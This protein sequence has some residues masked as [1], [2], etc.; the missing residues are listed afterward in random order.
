VLLTHS[1]PLDSSSRVAL[2]LALQKFEPKGKI[3]DVESCQQFLRDFHRYKD[4]GGSKHLSTLLQVPIDPKISFISNFSSLLYGFNSDYLLIDDYVEEELLKLFPATSS[5]FN[6]ASRLTQLKMPETSKTDPT[7]LITF[8]H[9]FLATFSYY[10]D[11]FK[12]NFSSP[13]HWNKAICKLFCSLLRP[14][15]LP[16]RFNL[17]EITEFNT[18]QLQFRKIVMQLQ[19]SQ[20]LLGKS[21]SGG[22]IASGGGVLSCRN[23]KLPHTVSD[24]KKP[25]TYST[26]ATSP[27]H[28]AKD[29][30]NWKSTKS[31]GSSSLSHSPPNKAPAP[32][33]P[34]KVNVA[35]TLPVVPPSTSS[36]DPEVIFDSGSAVTTIP[37]SNFRIDTTP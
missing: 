15:D 2:D 27:P 26:C 8:L 24:C 16:T 33:G 35:T 36:V 12:K 6:A 10:G 18:L 17:Q 1:P 7:A 22:G 3:I 21:A 5:A 32:R 25:C 14:S 34:P 30:P 28:Q 9:N 20:Q 23:C 31:K 13:L 37:T 19:T 11:D 4:Q 29:C